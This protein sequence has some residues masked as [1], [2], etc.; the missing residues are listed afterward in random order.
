MLV[1]SAFAAGD[2]V[3]TDLDQ[4]PLP[5]SPAELL[6]PSVARPV[7]AHIR[8]VATGQVLQFELLDTKSLDATE[9]VRYFA[10]A[11]KQAG[12]DSPYWRG[13]AF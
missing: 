5:L 7:L 11:A 3:V 13:L 2:V 4:Q 12:P 9:Y 10:A 6:A 1:L 8:D